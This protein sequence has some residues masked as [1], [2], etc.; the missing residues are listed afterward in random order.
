MH[1]EVATVFFPRCLCQ[2]VSPFRLLCHCLYSRRHSYQRGLFLPFEGRPQ[3]WSHSDLLSCDLSFRALY[4]RVISTHLIF[5]FV[6][7][8]AILETERR[9]KAL[10]ER[11]AINWVVVSYCGFKFFSR[12]RRH[13]P[14]PFLWL[15]EW[16]YVVLCTINARIKYICMCVCL[17]V[18]IWKG[19][20]RV[21]GVTLVLITLTNVWV[22]YR[23]SG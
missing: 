21:P 2:R 1:H 22:T 9:I 14:S 12:K 19:K 8:Q 10:A 4:L 23:L 13:T 16:E 17:F 5:G 18:Y 11:S 6:G 7:L 15:Q 3:F 20:R